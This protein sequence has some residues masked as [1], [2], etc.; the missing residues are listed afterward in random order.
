MPDLLRNC[1]EG[2]G[3]RR[4]STLTPSCFSS[5]HRQQMTRASF[6]L[7]RVFPTQARSLSE[8]T[9]E[10]QPQQS[11]GRE[12]KNLSCPE[13]EESVEKVE[14]GLSGSRMSFTRSISPLLR[15]TWFQLANFSQMSRKRSRSMKASGGSQ[16]SSC[17]SLDLC[18]IFTSCLQ[19]RCL[20]H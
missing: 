7:S 2:Q 16:R 15:L 19:H 9:R 18:L 4:S 5:A 6:H 10:V 20:Q 3:C 11:E 13:Q 8:V 12:R 14:L 1:A 17:S